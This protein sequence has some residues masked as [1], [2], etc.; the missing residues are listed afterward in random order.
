VSLQCLQPLLVQG[1]CLKVGG[2]DHRRWRLWPR[3]RI[4]RPEPLRRCFRLGSRPRRQLPRVLEGRARPGTPLL[5]HEASR[6]RDCA[7]DEGAKVTDSLAMGQVPDTVRCF[8][9]RSSAA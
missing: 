2:S 6:L 3:C 4:R 9:A 7:R 8:F 1:N 5:C